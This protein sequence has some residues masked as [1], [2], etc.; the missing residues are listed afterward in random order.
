MDHP[1]AELGFDLLLALG[2]VIALGSYALGVLLDP[3]PAVILGVAIAATGAAVFA[4]RGARL[5]ALA[6]GTGT[7]IVAGI[8]VPRV[9][10]GLVDPRVPVGNELWVTVAASIVVV[11][12]GVLLVRLT[13]FRKPDL[14]A[15]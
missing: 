12:A 10:L 9:I 2:T 3:L 4:P 11:L 6:I 7:V 5:P 8:L 15:A 13:A 1:A 14:R